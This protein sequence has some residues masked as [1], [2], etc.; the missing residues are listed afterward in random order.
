MK[1]QQG[2]VMRE[3]AHRELNLGASNIVRIDIGLPRDDVNAFRCTWK[4]SGLTNTYDME[5]AH[6]DSLGALLYAIEM[7]AVALHSSPEVESGLLVWPL[8]PSSSDLG[9]PEPPDLFGDDL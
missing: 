5:A 7:T 1:S 8:Q 6:V 3:V 9:L 4:I 2:V